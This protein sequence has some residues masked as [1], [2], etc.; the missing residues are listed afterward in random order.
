MAALLYEQLFFVVCCF[1]S[2]LSIVFQNLDLTTKKLV[3]DGSL[4]W[5][6]SR[7]KS[8]GK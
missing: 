4:T 8:I 3:Y 6:I 1:M 7:T 5:R 2:F